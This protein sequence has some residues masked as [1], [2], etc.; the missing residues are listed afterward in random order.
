MAMIVVHVGPRFS[1]LQIKSFLNWAAVR[2][3]VFSLSQA[4]AGFM[5]RSDLVR[6]FDGS[7]EVS[8]WL[9][10]VKLVAKLRKITKLAAFIPLFLEGPAFAV[11]D[12]LSDASKDDGE[13]IE[14][15]L[16]A[17]FGHKKFTAYDLFRQRS[18]MA[19]E[20]V[21]VFLGDL[22]R[23]A[24]LAEVE[25]EELICRAFVC[26]LLSDVSSNLRAGARISKEDLPTIVEK[27]RVLMDERIQG[28]MVAVG[29]GKVPYP[30]ELDARRKVECYACG[31][32]HFVRFCKN[33]KR[34]P[35]TCWRCDT[36]GHIARNCPRLTHDQG[37]GLGELPAPAASLK[38]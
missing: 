36:E 23:P 4:I 12:Q 31:G 15:A 3:V 18:W 33:K 13:E 19:G 32:N 6:P 1:F 26:G 27:A 24:R 25:S 29:R 21:D 11:Y 38:E 34:T 37:N 17:A 16:L 22:R 28:A 20:A 14:K 5:E 8:S 35:V 7:A 2:A 9:K 30:R 10:K